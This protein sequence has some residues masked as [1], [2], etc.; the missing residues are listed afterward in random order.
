MAGARRQATPTPATSRPPP[1]GGRL[2]GS[3]PPG[4]GPAGCRAS[5]VRRTGPGRAAS[6][7]PGLPPVR[8]VPP[9]RVRGGSRRPSGLRRACPG[10]VR[11]HRPGAQVQPVVEVPA[12][13]WG[14]V[15]PSGPQARWPR[16]PPV[17]PAGAWGASHVRRRLAAGLPRP[18]DSG[19]P[20]PPRPGSGSCVACA[21]RAHPRRPPPASRA[22]GPAL[23]GARSPRR[24]PGDAVDASPLVC[25]VCVPTTPPGTPDAR[26]GGG[27]PVPDRNVHP[28]RDAQLVVARQR[29]SSAARGLWRVGCMPWLGSRAP[30]VPWGLGFQTLAQSDLEVRARRIRSRDQRTIAQVL[31]ETEVRG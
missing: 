23:Q 11:P 22:A 25:A 18:G 1:T 5:G 2:G 7:R 27:A 9:R 29:H 21:A 24:P 3:P 8:G 12:S 13:S 26:R 28:A 14:R 20:A 10:L 16:R 30:D 17:P 4:G 19:G 31:I 6:G 15:S